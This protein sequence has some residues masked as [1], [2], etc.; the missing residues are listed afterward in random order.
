MTAEVKELLDNYWSWLRDKTAL[1]QIGNWVEV[2]TP[3]LDRHNDYLQIFVKKDGDKIQLTDD[4]YII[5]DLQHSGCDLNSKKRQQLL[6]TVLNG[7]G[8]QLQG[9]ALTTTATS[10]N[11]A[12]KKHGLVQAMLSVSD[13]FYVASANV[14]SLFLE[15]VAS[16][17]EVSDVRYV[18]DAKFTGKSGNDHLIHFVIPASKR[19]PARFLQTINRPDRN[20]AQNFAF[21][22][23][24]IREVREPTTQAFAMI[25]DSEKNPALEVLRTFEAYD[26]RPILWSERDNV[27]QQLVA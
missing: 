21:T 10:A 26:I 3:Y 24:D 19:A 9:E 16:W 2:T 25:N 6:E 18:S 23:V 22:W 12:Q 17:L 8:I 4:A 1:R 15:D 7:F 13:L 27:R 20:S 5:Q 14:K 11:F